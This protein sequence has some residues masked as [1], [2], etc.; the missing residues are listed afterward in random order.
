[1]VKML[2]FSLRPVLVS[3]SVACFVLQ[4]YGA[5][6]NDLQHIVDTFKLL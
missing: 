6:A 3:L 1:M 2:C 5:A 4:L